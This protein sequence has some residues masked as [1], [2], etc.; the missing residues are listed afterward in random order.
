MSNIGNRR[1]SEEIVAMVGRRVSVST[2]D[3]KK[4]D[5]DLIGIDERLN[6]I[7][8]AVIGVESS[9]RVVLNGTFVK[10]IDLLEKPFDLRALNE[11][12]SRAFPG[13]TK[14]REDIGAIL[15]M[16][17]I[18]VTEKGVVEGADRLSATRVKQIYEEFARETSK[19]S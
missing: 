10:E 13:M 12:L 18:K 19:K 15:V 11:R 5:G 7:L 2:G 4:Y 17:S 14:L 9:L 8:G 16:D 3:G 1:F 6:L